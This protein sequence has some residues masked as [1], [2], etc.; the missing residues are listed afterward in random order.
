MVLIAR[1]RLRLGDIDGGG[2]DP[3]VLQRFH[4]R[5]M[6]E[7]ATTRHVDQHGGRFHQTQFV[8]PDNVARLWRHGDSDSD[9]VSLAQEI[10]F[11]RVDD[12]E[13]FF[14]LW[15]AVAVVIEY[16]HVKALGAAGQLGADIAHANDAQRGAVNLVAM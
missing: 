11:G 9:I 14:S 6:V 8:A 5:V 12:A 10:L 15:T 13:C 3:L 7:N 4:Q 2:V 1:Q 16:L